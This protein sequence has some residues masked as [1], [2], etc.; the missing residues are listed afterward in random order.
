MEMAIVESTLD[1]EALT[2]MI[3]E[4]P[5]S[6]SCKVYNGQIYVG[7]LT[8]R[9]DNSHT[10]IFQYDANYK[11]PALCSTMPKGKELLRSQGL[12][13]FFRNLVSEGW[14]EEAQ[15]EVLI[16]YGTTISHFDIL[17]HF[18]EDCIGAI[19]V[20]P[21]AKLPKRTG[22]I[23]EHIG[24][25]QAHRNSALVPG[26]QPKI[27]M[28]EKADGEYVVS[29]RKT[30]STHIAKLEHMAKTAHLDW[31]ADD[32]P[33]P[34]DILCNEFVT[35][36][37][38]RA[39]LPEDQTCAVELK[40]L[41]TI[42]QEALLIKRFDRDDEGNPIA[43]YELNQLLGKNTDEKYDGYYKD[44]ADFIRKHATGSVVDGIRTNLGDIEVLFKRLLATILVENGDAHM[45]NFAL[46][47]KGDEFRLSPNYD[48][49]SCARPSYK[50]LSGM[51]LKIGYPAKDTLAMAQIKPKHIVA[52]ARD[53]GLLS[54]TPTLEEV[55]N[56]ASIVNEIV[57]RAKTI[58]A[59]LEGKGDV[60]QFPNLAKIMDA[61]IFGAEK[62]TA[63]CC[64]TRRWNGSLAGVDMFMNKTLLKPQAAVHPKKFVMPNI[65]LRKVL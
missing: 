55:S 24:A 53:L 16:S 54:E 19:R 52:L 64:L 41:D 3:A 46:L 37:V 43:C 2:T 47:Q 57:G 17:A 36:E 25:K 32:A 58:C 48:S 22:G 6:I 13:P 38:L 10:T 5:K 29:S 40:Y 51:A 14:L 20:V 9:P 26:I 11:G 7:I 61:S 4:A 45:K 30:R 42:K 65:S 60:Q 34:Q 35:T 21:C 33:P 39:L 63:I 31:S 23:L 62:T 44:I 8:R 49:V 28:T 27:L 12:F 59:I 56:I 18:G 15:K 1:A 50:K